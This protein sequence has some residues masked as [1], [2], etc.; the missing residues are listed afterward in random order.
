MDN[1]HILL[2]DNTHRDVN[3]ALVRKKGTACE[4]G[5]LALPVN[6]VDA[7][8]HDMVSETTTS[9][10]S[11]M[12]SGDMNSRDGREV[13]IGVLP[14]SGR[15]LARRA[16]LDSTGYSRCITSIRRKR[17]KCADDIRFDESA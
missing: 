3:K 9:D 2:H 16:V 1:F 5:R 10:E 4:E 15:L 12:V 8:Y 13:E 6:G 17:K 14:T 7:D 11:G